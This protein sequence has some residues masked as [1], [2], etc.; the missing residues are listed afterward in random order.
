[1]TN[2]AN[3]ALIAAAGLVLA[4]CSGG[5]GGSS[6]TPP[7]TG[8]VT[9]TGPTFTQNSFAPA[10]DFVDRCA[11][12]RTG[13]DIE[14]NGFPDSQGTLIE[15]LFWLRSWTE[16]TYLFNDEVVDR[17]PYDFESEGRVA[18][19]NVLRTTAVTPSGEDKDD[20][21]F[22]QS[23]EGFLA[24]RNA[25]PTASYGARFDIV[26]PSVPREV[27]VVYSDPDTPASDVVGGLQQFVR[28][29]SILTVDG[30]DLVNDGSQAA[31]DALNAGLFPASAGETHVFEVLDP[32]ATTPRT[33]TLVSAS[34]STQPINAVE[35]INTP[36]GDVGYIH[37]TTFSPFSSEA[38]IVDAISQLEDA[39][40]SDLVLD[41]RYN[42]GG[43]LAVAAE[44][45]FMIAG[46]SRT[47]GR[48]FEQ[49]R[50]NN[51]D[52][53]SCV[54]PIFGAPNDPIPFY[55]TGQGFSVSSG[56]P[57]P[58]LN[59][60]RVFI[61]STESTCSASEAVINGLRGVDVEVILI[62][63]ITCGKPFGFFPTDNCGETYFTIQF[64]GLND[65]G[66]GDFE[67][68]FVPMDSSF[69]FGV[70]TPGCEIADDFSQPLGNPNEAL[71]AAALQYRENSTCPTPPPTALAA[72]PE[73]SFGTFRDPSTAIDVPVPSIFETNRDMTR[74][75]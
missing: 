6:S 68:G 41:L 49:L 15:E 74:P 1:M 37:F 50:Y 73:T 66:F 25:A 19:F 44:L 61:L 24:A 36:T 70:R 13:V 31:V 53:P 40:V 59:L 69:G 29:A 26:S 11:A 3:T 67:D 54:D 42:G 39:N 45:G 7:P 51:C 35:V 60:N 28:G 43:L 30:F 57:L 58:S 16:E 23:T 20:F 55:S 4:A 38:A 32:G 34:L 64:Q 2:A 22:S 33:V 52:N 27:R 48:T 12:P 46:N 71:L 8:G 65:K 18:Y 10:S 5:G 62:G 75:Q 21:H 72:A 9:P 47:A 63:G 14:G 56:T 17:N